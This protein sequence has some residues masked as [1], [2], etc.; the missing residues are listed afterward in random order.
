MTYRTIL[1]NRQY[2]NNRNNKHFCF[3]FVLSIFNLIQ[4]TLPSSGAKQTVDTFT[5]RRLILNSSE[6]KHSQQSPIHL[7]LRKVFTS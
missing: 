1:N 4:L 3:C 2:H 5:S 7:I 6:T